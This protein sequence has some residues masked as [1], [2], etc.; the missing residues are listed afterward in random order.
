MKLFLL[1]SVIPAA[2]LLSETAQAQIGIRA[3]ANYTTL[4]A[5]RHN[6]SSFGSAD[7][8]TGFQAGIFYEK[9]LS[10]H[11]SLVPEV[12]F[13]RQRLDFTAWNYDLT[14]GYSSSYQT[15]LSYLSVPV[16]LRATLGRFYLEAGPQVGLLLAAHEKGTLDK[17]SPLSSYRGPDSYSRFDG[18]ATGQYRRTDAGLSAGVGMK[19]PAG[20]A[21][22]LRAYA[23]LLSITRAQ[24]PYRYS[25]SLKNRVVQAS[26]SYCLGKL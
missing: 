18:S 10:A 24:Q 12:Q 11:F 6:N 19:L 5:E 16:L 9:R 14:E 20:F 26:V 17:A 8:R 7:G 2:L 21:V 3:G 1:I 4:S 15:A 25:G 23:G 22:G 13:S